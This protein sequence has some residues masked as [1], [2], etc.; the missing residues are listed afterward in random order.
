[1]VRVRAYKQRRAPIPITGR[2]SAETRPGTI[3]TGARLGPQVWCSNQ[4]VEAGIQIA[5][6]QFDRARVL[7]AMGVG[8][9]PTQGGLWTSS[10]LSR[11]EFCSDWHRWTKDK[12][13]MVP[14]LEDC[15]MITPDPDARI[16]NV[17]TFE[18]LKWLVQNYRQTI[19]TY[20]ESEY[21][22]DW[23]KV[24]KDFDAVHLT[25]RGQIQTRYTKPGFYEWDAESTVWLRPKVTGRRFAA[26]EVSCLGG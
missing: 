2:N 18:D 24:A 12:N 7:P 3:T 14:Q 22:I 6:P 9:K 16:Y 21:D 5:R 13:F 23:E 1:M 19:P 17:D 20:R 15:W 10:Y 25:T 26:A 8:M 11:G 4:F